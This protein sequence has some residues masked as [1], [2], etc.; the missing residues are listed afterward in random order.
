MILNLCTMSVTKYT[1]ESFLDCPGNCHNMLTYI[2]SFCISY[3]VW[4][5]KKMFHYM[6]LTFFTYEVQYNKVIIFRVCIFVFIFILFFIRLVVVVAFLF[7]FR[8]VFTWNLPAVA[9]KSQLFEQKKPKC[10]KAID[11][12]YF[13]SD[14]IYRKIFK[15]IIIII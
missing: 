1:I 3:F 8:C 6:N 7:H 4:D 5:K 10:L 15:R 11:K 2:T 12:S 9:F 14:F 13:G